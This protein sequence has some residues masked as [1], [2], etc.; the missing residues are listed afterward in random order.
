MARAAFMELVLRPLVWLLLAPAVE[1]RKPLHRPSLVIAN[2]V[3]AL[4]PAIL[5]YALRAQDRD[6][7]AIAMAGDIITGWRSG[8]TQKHHL[9]GILAPLAYWLVTALFNV[10]PLPRGG[11][12]RRSFAHAGE[13][14]DRGYHVLVFPEGRRSPDGRLQ[15]FE[16]GIGLLA[17]D[18]QVPVQPVYLDGLGPLKLGRRSWFRPGTVTI[19]LGE[20]L[21]IETGEKP[22]RFAQRLQAAMECLGDQGTGARDQD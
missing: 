19:R 10:F 7:V 21:S 3:T 13:A 5:L 6:H 9:L 22:A 16:S 2:H 8:K 1:G 15:A 11:G 20:P 18:S 14:L 12:L 4:D 17:Q